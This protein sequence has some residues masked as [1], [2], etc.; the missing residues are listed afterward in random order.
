MVSRR[1]ACLA[2]A[3][4]AEPFLACLP[5]HGLPIETVNGG[6]DTCTVVADAHPPRP[7][8]CFASRFKWIQL[9]VNEIAEDLDNSI[10]PAERFPLTLVRHRGPGC[11]T[12]GIAGWRSDATCGVVSPPHR[13]V[14]HGDGHDQADTANPSV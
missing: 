5:S 8:N 2:G 13:R 12:R 4:S 11:R 1:L 3:T 7:H 10:G 9:D 14:C 6:Q